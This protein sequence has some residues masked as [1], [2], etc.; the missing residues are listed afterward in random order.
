MATVHPFPS[1]KRESIHFVHK[2]VAF[3]AYLGLAYITYNPF[4]QQFLAYVIFALGY[5]IVI[6]P[7]RYKFPSFLRFHLLQALFS[8]LLLSLV[9]RFVLLNTTLLSA[10]SAL[11]GVE[12]LFNKGLDWFYSIV[13][14]PGAAMLCLALVLL[15]LFYCVKGDS[16]EL[17]W[18]GAWAQRLS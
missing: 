14:V 15:A 17:P 6:Q 8:F 10:L 3:L 1:R 4:Y 2:L 12:A 9:F 13:F 16:K 5:W 18:V 7:R 11:F